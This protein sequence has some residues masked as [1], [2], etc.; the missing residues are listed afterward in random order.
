MTRHYGICFRPWSASRRYSPWHNALSPTR[1]LLYTSRLSRPATHSPVPAAIGAAQRTRT[2]LAAQ[3][4][5][6]L[7][8][9]ESAS[10]H[11]CCVGVVCIS[12][13]RTLWPAAERR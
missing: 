2:V 1:L 3:T 4:Y 5:H 7:G 9:N 13:V 8:G 11:Q 6:R 10:A 12:V